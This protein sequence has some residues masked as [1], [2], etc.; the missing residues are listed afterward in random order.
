MAQNNVENLMLM[1]NENTPFFQQNTRL[2]F[3]NSDFKFYQVLK[4]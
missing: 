3:E 2:I 4:K 1:M